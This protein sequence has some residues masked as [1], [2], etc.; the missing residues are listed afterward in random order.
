MIVLDPE[1]LGGL[2]PPSKLTTSIDGKDN[3]TPFARLPRLERLRIQG[4]SDE[5]EVPVVEAEEDGEED[6]ETS[7]EEEE[8]GAGGTTSRVERE[9]KRMKGRNKTLKRYVRT[10]HVQCSHSASDRA[11]VVSYASS[12]KMSLILK[13]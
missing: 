5:T 4:K 9:K 7:S 13:R 6:D 11:S 3:G 8:N 12:V 1:F 10:P 2:A